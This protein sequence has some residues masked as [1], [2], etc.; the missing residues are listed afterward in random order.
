[1]HAHRLL[2]MLL[3]VAALSGCASTSDRTS[4]QPL[5]GSGRGVD[6]VTI[7]TSNV[8]AAANEYATRLGFTVGPVRDFPFGFSGANIYFEDGTY[9]E[10]YGIHDADKVASIGEGFA[11]DAPEGVRWM[12]LHAR[13][14]ADSVNRL[15]QRGI[16]AWGP[17]EL[18]EGSGQDWLYRLAGLEEPGLPGGRVYFVEYK[19]EFRAERDA[20]NAAAIRTRE[21]HENGAVGLR[22][23]WIA[24]HDL[25]AAA[26]RYESAG[27]IPGPRIPLDVLD[28]QAREIRTTGGTILLVQMK[29]DTGTSSVHPSD[30][31][32][33]ISI[34]TRSLDTI[35][36][37]IRQSH[38]LDLTPYQ[39]LYGRSILLPSTF[40]RGASIEFFE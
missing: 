28:T 40:A 29:P 16:P 37:R 31:F 21:T 30:S 36:A 8:K 9:M 1:M 19:G 13:P 38:S 15:K 34:R 14:T 4:L 17:F 5:L 24:V 27:L 39:G 32:A 23:V 22:S 12:T 7:L 3:L 33:G 35:R 25:S 11:L 2:L 6:H 18:P 20:L 26:A 10:L